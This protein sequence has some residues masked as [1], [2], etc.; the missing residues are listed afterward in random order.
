MF[1]VNADLDLLGGMDLG[2]PHYT[3]ADNDAAATS[4]QQQR[5]SS[6]PGSAATTPAS[7]DLAGGRDPTLLPSGADLYAIPEGD[8]DQQLDQFDRDFEQL[9]TLEPTPAAGAGTASEG[10]GGEGVEDAA[11]QQDRA[12]GDTAEG[13]PY[14]EAGV[15]RMHSMCFVSACKRMHMCVCM[16]SCTCVRA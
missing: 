12:E 15:Y 1:D 14:L 13:G 5:S 11:A 8:F 16:R 9:P 6:K 4:E 2:G 10:R 7:S 3:A